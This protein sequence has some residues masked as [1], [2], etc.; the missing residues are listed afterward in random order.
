VT[1]RCLCDHPPM[2]RRSP[3]PGPQAHLLALAVGSAIALLAAGCGTTPPPAPTA[4]PSFDFFTPGPSA[5]PEDP[6]AVY[7]R[8]E[9]QVQALRGL[10][11]KVTVDPVVLDQA[12][13]DA[14][15]RTQ[16][17][18]NNPAAVV[19]ATQRFDQALGLI[20]ADASLRDLELQLLSG[21]VVGFYDS[22]TKRMS[23]KSVGGALGVAQQLTFA[24]E[25]DH[26]LQ[27]QTFDLPKLGIDA[28]DQSDRSLGRLA[29]VEGDAT[30][31][32]SDW[33]QT[34]LTPLQLLQ[35]LSRADITGQQA[36]LAKMPAALKA[37]L[38]FPYT[39]GLT[40]VQGLQNKGGWDAVNQ[41]FA[42][43]PDS[44]EQVLHPEKYAAHE[45]PV[46]V[47]VPADLATRL[48]DGWTVDMQDTFGEFG[49]RTWLQTVGGF[50]PADAVTAAD[51]WGGDRV[52]LVSHGTDFAI[53]I[54]TV[55]DT[56][57]DAT[58]FAEAAATTRGKLSA[59]SALIDPGMTNKVT[60]FVASNAAAIQR[61]AGALGLA[62]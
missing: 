15:L 27:D 9:L 53:A 59:S 6:A 3:S 13:I 22:E 2:S 36:I 62:G 33:A 56:P 34:A 57:A 31:L 8:I 12:A 51:G 40:F 17:D 45:A 43:P 35:Y 46:A 41:A 61:L 25:F 48:G 37:Q 5:T 23:V 21:Q 19:A 30:V 7:A 52:V 44:T 4:P 38:L 39:T 24:H 55:W 42:A 26:A 18:K 14:A 47:S 29:L 58:A 50:A 16:F 20:P 32:M 60:V 28:A 49:L 54:Q 1:A 10:K 11:A